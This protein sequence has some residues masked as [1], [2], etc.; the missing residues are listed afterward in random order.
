MREFENDKLFRYHLKIREF[1]DKAKS[2]D[3]ELLQKIKELNPVKYYC[4]LYQN[5]LS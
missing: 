2:T 1:D 5:T 3:K 4:D